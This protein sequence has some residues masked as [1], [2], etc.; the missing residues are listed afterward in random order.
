M[1]RSGTPFNEMSECDSKWVR[2][3]R[4][5]WGSLRIRTDCD[6]VGVGPSVTRGECSWVWLGMSLE[7]CVTGYWLG[8]CLWRVWMWLCAGVWGIVSLWERRTECECDY[9]Y[10]QADLSECVW[11]GLNET[12]DWMKVSGVT[13]HECGRVWVGFCGSKQDCEWMALSWMIM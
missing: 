8:V 13:G 4:V 3:S 5:E 12:K 2:G 10:E 11:V 1:Q 7:F 9:D 6:Q